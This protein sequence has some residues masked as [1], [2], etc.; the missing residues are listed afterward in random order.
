MDATGPQ[1]IYV[2]RHAEKPDEN[3]P[4]RAPRGV[5]ESGE[6]SAESLTPRGWQRAGA[7]VG[8]FAGSGGRTTAVPG[9]APTALLA[10]DYAKDAGQHRAEETLAPL[11]RM[12]GLDVES[13]ASKGEE[14]EL[15]AGVMGMDGHVLVCWEHH[16]IADIVAALGKAAVLGDLP[17]LA[18]DWPDDVFDQVLVFTRDGEGYAA[19]CVPQRLLDGDTG[20]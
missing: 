3:H 7:L 5:D 8:F 12:L 10:P 2:I 20:I 14:D 19:S 9:P 13:P 18:T 15:V 11:G 17:P 6:P 4:D 1:T 16:R